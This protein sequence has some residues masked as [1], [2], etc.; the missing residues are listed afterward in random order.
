[1][2]DNATNHR[3]MAGM[4]DRCGCRHHHAMDGPAALA[5]LRSAAD[6]GEP[7][8]VA[9]LDMM[10]PGMDGEELG[11]AIAADP[12]IAST[13]LVML[14]SMGTPG[15]AKRLAQ[16]QFAAYLTKPIRE[17]QLRAC[18]MMLAGRPRPDVQHGLVTRHTIREASRH[19]RILLAE[20][21]RTNQKVATILLERL[22]H[23]VVLAE[24]GVEAV[25]A[26]RAEPFDLV[27]MDVQMPEMDGLEAT[28]RIRR[29][30]SGAER[31]GIP[32]VAM[33]AHA[34]KGDREQ[35]LE[36]GMDAYLAKP[37]KPTDLRDVIE[38]LVPA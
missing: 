17:G 27:L 3:V 8:R 21:N 13:T 24:S 35:C 9:V 10:M 2:D 6:S 22:G 18:L 1:V 19:L 20:D 23:R 14:T 37:I 38:R 4:L 31:T 25:D 29:G 15:D 30:E 28:R 33:T 7:F 5:R 12:A 32:I 26:L 11:A 36:S 34:M 16:R